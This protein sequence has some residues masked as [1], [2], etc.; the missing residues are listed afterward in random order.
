MTLQFE[1]TVHDEHLAQRIQISEIK[2][3]CRAF[4]VW[5]TTT[6]LCLIAASGLTI[7]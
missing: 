5:K 7:V 6:S 1:A 4:S 3:D 2:L